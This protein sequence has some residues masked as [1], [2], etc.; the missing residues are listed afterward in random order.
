M[1]YKK[2]KAL[3]TLIMQSKKVILPL[4]LHYEFRKSLEESKSLEKNLCAK[5][6]ILNTGIN[7][8]S[9]VIILP[10][11]DLCLIRL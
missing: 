3:L 6:K 7:V 1:Q 10:W 9:K 2:I 5:V 11:D 8:T 4:Q